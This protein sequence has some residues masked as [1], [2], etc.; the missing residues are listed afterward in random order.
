MFISLCAMGSSISISWPKQLVLKKPPFNP[1]SSITSLKNK[2][3]KLWKKE[4]SDE[5]LKSGIARFYDESSSIWLDVWGEHMHHGY[6]PTSDYNEHQLAQVD[7]IDR[8]I[9]WAYGETLKDASPKSIGSTATF[10]PVLM[11][12]SYLYGTQSM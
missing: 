5:D 11:L 6:Y 4:R 7:M 3:T 1:F 8:S 12:R 9:D 2:W 10:L